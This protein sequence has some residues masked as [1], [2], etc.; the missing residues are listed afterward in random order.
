M[1]ASGDAEGAE[2][3]AL[4]PGGRLDAPEGGAPCFVYDAIETAKLVLDVPHRSFLNEITSIDGSTLV[5]GKSTSNT[6]KWKSGLLSV[7]LER[8]LSAVQQLPKHAFV[9]PRIGTASSGKS[10][11][12]VRTKRD[13]DGNWEQ[14]PPRTLD[15]SLVLRCGYSTLGGGLGCQA[16]LLIGFAFADVEAAIAGVEPMVPLHVAAHACGK[17]EGGMRQAGTPQPCRHPVDVQLGS[18]GRAAAGL[19][20]QEARVEGLSSATISSRAVATTSGTRSTQPAWR[21]DAD[22]RVLSSQRMTFVSDLLK[23]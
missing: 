17:N 14:R 11:R 13:A 20:R 18:V 15:V 23:A 7:F 9:D 3:S 21:N 2:A 12:A 6:L 8:R 4:P 1:S 16:E 19:R 5:E 10:Q 22:V